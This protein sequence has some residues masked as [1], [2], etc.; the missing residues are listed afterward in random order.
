MSSPAETSSRLVDGGGR[1]TVTVTVDGVRAT[2]AM[3]TL[4]DNNIIISTTGSLGSDGVGLDG[5]VWNCVG[6]DG[7]AVG[8][9]T[10]SAPHFYGH[11]LNSAL[12][13]RNNRQK[14]QQLGTT[15]GI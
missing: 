5:F 6:W 14:P 8:A 11:M 15:A 3:A 12:D 10:T 4:G 7:L 1:V 13:C 9:S 2:M